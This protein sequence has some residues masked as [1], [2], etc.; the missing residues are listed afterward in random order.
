M[1]RFGFTLFETAI[2]PCGIAWDERGAV[3]AVQL[4]EVSPRATRER[5]RRRCPG[6]A[7]AAPPLHLQDVIDGLTALLRGEPRDLAAVSLDMANLPSF[8]RRVYE[9]ARTILPGATLTYGAVA[10]R[11]GEPAAAREVGEALGANP[12]PL[13]V[14]CHRVVA[15]DGRLGGFSAHGGAVTKRRLLWIEGAPAAGTADLFDPPPA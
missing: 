11:L 5:L 15:A 14:P 6:A 13:L 1:A 7:E 10:A 8:Q 2:R 12:F 9:V 3:R 4:P